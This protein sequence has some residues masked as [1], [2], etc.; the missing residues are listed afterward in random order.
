[1]AEPYLQNLSHNLRTPSRRVA[2]TRFWPPP[3]PLVRAFSPLTPDFA[4][5]KGW[6][7]VS[8]S[9]SGSRPHPF[10][11]NSKI[12]NVVAMLTSSLPQTEDG[13]ASGKHLKNI[14][15]GPHK[16][17]LMRWR[18]SQN[19]SLESP[20]PAV[21]GGPAQSASKSEKRKKERQPTPPASGPFRGRAQPS[22]Q[23][24]ASQQRRASVTTRSPGLTP[25]E[26]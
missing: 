7:R 16:C 1:M 2:Q 5:P 24:R 23:H 13:K 17:P 8:Q 19:R 26:G 4:A 14:Q 11:T 12:N 22:L 20:R 25:N 21:P 6:L 9:D 15:F 3:L 10:N 18:L